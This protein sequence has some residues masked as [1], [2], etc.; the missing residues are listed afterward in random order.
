M[1]LEGQTMEERVEEIV[2]DVLSISYELPRPRP[3]TTPSA[4][5]ETCGAEHDQ[6]LDIYRQPNGYR[7]HQLGTCIENMR[8]T[9]AMLRDRVEQLESIALNRGG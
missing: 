6:N 9:I 7:T 5:C 4:T 3:G 2:Q 8:D 1:T